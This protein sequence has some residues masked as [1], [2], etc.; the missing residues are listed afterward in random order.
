MIAELPRANYRP[1][2][3]AWWLASCSRKRSGKEKTCFKTDETRRRLLLPTSTTSLRRIDVS[4]LVV[5]SIHH[6][7]KVG[8]H[9]R[10][11]VVVCT[12]SLYKRLYQA[13]WGRLSKTQPSTSQLGIESPPRSC[14]PMLL[15]AF[16]SCFFSFFLNVLRSQTM[17]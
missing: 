8:T 16:S 17:L 14:G 6:R 9:T 13:G 7:S 3:R 11:Y 4:L 10:Y 2:A 5:L 12:T 1:I 15:A